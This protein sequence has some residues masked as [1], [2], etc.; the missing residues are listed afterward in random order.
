[1]VFGNSRRLFRVDGRV[2]WAFAACILSVLALGTATG[3][4]AI[5]QT[6]PPP[7]APGAA[8]AP[9]QTQP[10][11]TTATP[12]AS[13][14]PSPVPAASG[15]PAPQPPT[16]V[17]PDVY[18][19]SFK[20][21]FVLFILAVIIE[22]GFAVLFNWRPFVETFNSRSV[23]PLVAF[24]FCWLFVEAFDL[25][26]TTRL[27]NVYSSTNYPV[28][29]PGK[30]VTALVLAGG[31][32]GVNNLMVSLGFRAPISSTP[33]PARP[34]PNEAWIAVR[35][36]RRLARGPVTVRI[37]D[38]AAGALPVAGMIAGSAHPGGA[39]VS[40]FLRDRGRFPGTGGHRISVP[41]AAPPTV[42]VELEGVT[43]AGAAI[44]AAPGSSWGGYPVTAGA[45]IDLELTL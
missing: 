26:I 35:L 27:V 3:G 30:I 41:A 9:A 36:N 44:P 8:S 5:A 4:Q 42:R 29:L 18:S 1:M 28:N 22:S 16:L 6:G 45:V 20:A 34:P 10:A 38:P 14:A 21:L 24:A 33:A 23:K 2:R 15:Q 7:A 19:Q 12:A 17:S 37:G 25:D 40:Y 31:S 39:V 13:V 11:A 43:A 32:S